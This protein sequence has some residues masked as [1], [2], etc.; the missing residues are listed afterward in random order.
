[1][2]LAVVFPPS[3]L[4]EGTKSQRWSIHLRMIRQLAF[5]RFHPS[6]QSSRSCRSY[7]AR[8]FSGPGCNRIFSIAFR[9]TSSALS[10][11]A[12]SW[13]LS[14]AFSTV[15]STASWRRLVS[16]LSNQLSCERGEVIRFSVCVTV[17]HGLSQPKIENRQSKIQN[18]FT[19]SL[20]PHAQIHLAE[21]L[22][23]S[24]WPPSEV[25]SSPRH[26]G[27]RSATIAGT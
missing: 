9:T 24:A 7:A 4:M 12:P 8:V 14:R 23:R 13:F 3:E 5:S 10:P 11:A 26:I 2:S 20:D 19:G 15:C 22:A 6:S 18:C 1:M 25:R 21:S 27:W 17:G 16:M